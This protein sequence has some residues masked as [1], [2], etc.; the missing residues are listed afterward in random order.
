MKFFKKKNVAASENVAEKAI[1]SNENLNQKDNKAKE[2]N[3]T[4]KEAAFDFIKASKEFE[5]S[6]MGDIERSKKTAWIVATLS[7]GL[8]S[9][10]SV[11]ITVMMPLKTV[12]P[13]LVR[14]DN[15]TG[16]TDIV[17]ALSETKS[18]SDT[19]ATSKY[20]AALYVRLMEGYDWFTVQDQVSTLMLF[21]D[22]DMQNR[23]NN[24]FKMPNAPH[25]VHTDKERVEI[26]INNLSILDEQG[27]MQIRFTKRVVPSNGG[28]Y[29]KNTNQFSP[30]QVEEKYIATMGF[31]YV[32][33][34]KLDE[35]RLKN[36]LG[37]TVKSY[38]IDKDGI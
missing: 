10:L 13:Y 8:A 4:S 29:D 37:F 21:S 19:E 24:K 15:N 2:K 17:T 14:V 28:I 30:D 33:V 27:L 38:R 16:S 32:N 5:K 25:K 11:A 12:E 7:M 34:P 36:P 35:I 26:Q 6:R 3:V 23:I 31:E 1:I 22:A 9:L 18:I 20:F